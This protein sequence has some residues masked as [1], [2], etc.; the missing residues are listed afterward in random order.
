MDDSP[1]V[2]QR[3]RAR[4]YAEW[5]MRLADR[6]VDELTEGR[7]TEARSAKYERILARMQGIITR[8]LF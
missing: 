8:D 5:F 6:W 2:R 1:K 4:R 3:E 7:A